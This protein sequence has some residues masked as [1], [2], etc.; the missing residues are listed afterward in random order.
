[1]K[2]YSAMISLHEHEEEEDEEAEGRGGGGGGGGRLTTSGS[3]FFPSS[4]S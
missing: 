4:S 2:L 1:L 3:W